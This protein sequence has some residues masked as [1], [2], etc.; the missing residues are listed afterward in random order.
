[1]ERRKLGALLNAKADEVRQLEDENSSLSD[2]LRS[3]NERL[4]KIKKL[5]F[6]GRL[7]WSIQG[8]V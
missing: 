3:A 5:G 8:K 6:W 4:Q 7:A 2:A 1:M